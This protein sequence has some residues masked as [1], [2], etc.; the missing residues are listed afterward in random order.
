MAQMECVCKPY[1]QQIHDP[2]CAELSQIW[3]FCKTA[4]QFD[5]WLALWE[6]NSSLK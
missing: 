5:L 6:S 1:L 3:N 2:C 4:L